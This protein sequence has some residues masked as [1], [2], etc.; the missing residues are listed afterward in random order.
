MFVLLF[1]Y[2]SSEQERAPFLDAHHEYLDRQ[3]EA[4]SY[5]L[6]GAASGDRGLILA[7][8]EDGAEVGELLAG[9]PFVREG[10][11]ECEAI[12]IEIS[13]SAIEHLP[14]R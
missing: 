14:K 7:T 8:A 9:D 1:S 5:V 4:G 3:Y 12:E 13:R 6:W 10:L 2:P 11:V